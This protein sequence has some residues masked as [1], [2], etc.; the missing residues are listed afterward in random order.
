LFDYKFERKGDNSEKNQFFQIWIFLC[1]LKVNNFI[2][3]KNKWINKFQISNN[4]Y[5]ERKVWKWM[6]VY[7]GAGEW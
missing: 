3:Q 2:I 6:E 7:N 5:K 1:W 4:L